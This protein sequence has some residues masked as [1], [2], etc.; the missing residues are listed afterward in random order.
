[1]IRSPLVLESGGLGVEVRRGSGGLEAGGERRC[2]WEGTEGRSGF[3]FG[4]PLWVGEPPSLQSLVPDLAP[5]LLDFN[6]K[7]RSPFGLRE[8]S[9][10]RSPKEWERFQV[11]VCC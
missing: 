9:K 1:M 8:S 7:L 2:S 4:L 11:P 5:S 10:C 6:I 3:P